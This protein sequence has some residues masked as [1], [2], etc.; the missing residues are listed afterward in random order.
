MVFLDTGLRRGE[1]LRLTMADVSVDENTKKRMF[2]GSVPTTQ[3]GNQ[4]H[5]L[6]I[7]AKLLQGTSGGI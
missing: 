4:K 5:D 1:L 7:A 3:A 2:P 6:F